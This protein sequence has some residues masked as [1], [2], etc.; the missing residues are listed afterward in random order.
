M[1]Q[2]KLRPTF[3]FQGTFSH[4][5]LYQCHSCMITVLF[6]CHMCPQRHQ[7]SEKCQK[8]Q[9]LEGWLAKIGGKM[10]V[11]M[12]KWVTKVRYHVHS[13]AWGIYTSTSMIIKLCI[14]DY[15]IL[16]YSSIFFSDQISHL[17]SQK[18]AQ[19]SRIQ[20]DKAFFQKIIFLF[21]SLCLGKSDSMENQ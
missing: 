7:W 11:L 14:V 4:F 8:C 20:S 6:F 17:C 3:E 19:L 12:K 18:H 10:G 5:F 2:C 13:V 1:T 15:N 9:W 21:F 16:K